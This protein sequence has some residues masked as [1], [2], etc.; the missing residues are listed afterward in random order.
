M[1][2]ARIERD[3]A[4]PAALK[5]RVIA[6]EEWEPAWTV[7]LRSMKGRFYIRF[8]TKNKSYLHCFYFFFNYIILDNVSFLSKSI[9]N[10]K[11][12]EMDMKLRERGGGGRKSLKT[13][14]TCSGL[15]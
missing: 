3:G 1:A 9:S 2:A 5:R 11:I 8:C 14:K 6:S 4:S 12:L 13:L 15:T 7:R 10:E